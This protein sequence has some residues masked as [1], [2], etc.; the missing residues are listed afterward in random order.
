MKA[1]L[2]ESLY[3]SYP[4]IKGYRELVFHPFRSRRISAL[5]GVDLEVEAGECF[6][7]MGPNGAGKTTL[8]KI[9]STLV[10]PDKGKAFIYG[11][12]VTEH[13]EIVK[14]KIG[15][16]LSE[17]R[18]F[19]WRLTGRQNLE[20]FAVLNEI[21]AFDREEKIDQVLKFTGLEEA[22]GRRFNTYSAGMRQRLAIARALLS[23]PEV[24]FV[25]E[26]TRSLDPK[27]SHKLRS[28]LREEI[29]DN[30]GK[31]VFWATHDLDEAQDYAH[32]LAVLND[33]RIQAAGRVHELTRGGETTLRE[34]YNR[35][36]D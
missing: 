2:V 10:Y 6:C 22:A 35:C 8:I 28:F 20:F 3:K 14:E 7:L 9:L 11:A 21:R 26:P 5:N 34:V 15:Y 30:R 25:D 24:L 19:Y 18:S 16:A 12:D 27:A 23:D 1:V 4:V 13:P 32:R 17:E 36:T 29:A 31:T 33:G